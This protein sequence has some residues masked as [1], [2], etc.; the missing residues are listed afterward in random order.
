MND[1]EINEATRKVYHDQ[2]TRVANDSVAMAR[3]L[4]MVQESYFGLPENFFRNRRVLDAGCGDTA[5]LLIRFSQFGATDLVGLDLGTDFIPV[6]R[7]S[8]K[9]H[10]V[11]EECVRLVSGSVDALPFDD[12]EFDFV[13]CHG[14]LLHLA[15]MEQ[16]ENAFSELARVTKK[17]GWLY[18]VYGLHGGLFEAIYPVIRTYYREHEDF[19]NLIDNISPENFRELAEFVSKES[20]ANGIPLDIDIDA[21]SKMLD[22]DLCVTLQNIIQAPVRLPISEAFVLN[23]YSRHGF[24]PPRRL[25]RFVQRQN[26]RK[27]FAPLHYEHE[28]PV[29]KMLYGSGNLEFIARKQ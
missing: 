20:A 1:Q 21:V 18:T 16:V 6:A 13:C 9:R 10:G 3:F 24:A 29:S 17:G 26:I 5:K 25:Q 8:L 4:N 23:E 15:N 11:A 28:H 27:F 19:R 22:I 12:G 2:H 7:Q 14:V